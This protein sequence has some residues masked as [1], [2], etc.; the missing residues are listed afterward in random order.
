MLFYGACGPRY[1]SELNNCP[2]PEHVHSL[3]AAVEFLSTE[4]TDPLWPLAL[5][6]RV[7]GPGEPP[8]NDDV[9]EPIVDHPWVHEHMTKNEAEAVLSA[10][11]GLTDQGRHV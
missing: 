2:L 3:E 7:P 10:N 9:G 1:G 5:T 11:D 4:H 8:V 6:S